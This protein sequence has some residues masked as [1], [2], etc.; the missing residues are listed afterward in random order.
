MVSI[1]IKTVSHCLNR[2]KREKKEREKE[3]KKKKRRKREEEEKEDCIDP[4]AASSTAVAGAR[5]LLTGAR[6]LKKGKIEIF[7]TWLSNNVLSLPI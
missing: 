6:I 4:R 5:I 3:K 2:R 7:K 1:S